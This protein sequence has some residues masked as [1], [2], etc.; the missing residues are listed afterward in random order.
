MFPEP[1]APSQ[2][3]QEEISYSPDSDWIQESPGSTG[4]LLQWGKLTWPE[5]ET[6]RKWP[7]PCGSTPP[8]LT[9]GKLCPPLQHSTHFLPVQEGIHGE[10]A[11]E[12]PRDA[13]DRTSPQGSCVMY[14]NVN[15]GGPWPCSLLFSL[16]LQWACLRG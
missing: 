4:K 10:G 15:R 8:I 2:A 13:H 6:S 11:Q 7:P 12:W 16:S 9:C 3:I 1:V 5:A 14:I